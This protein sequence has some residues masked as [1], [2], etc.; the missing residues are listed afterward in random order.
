M[1]LNEEARDRGVE[2]AE[3]HLEKVLPE[4]TDFCDFVRKFFV[5]AVS[6][7]QASKE[8]ETADS[9]EPSEPD[10]FSEDINLMFVGKALIEMTASFDLSD[11]VARH[12]PIL[13]K[14]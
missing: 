12:D 13:S 10:E 4:L 2:E 5:D 6:D 9:D 1:F 8:A 11:E 7:K 14:R 3:T